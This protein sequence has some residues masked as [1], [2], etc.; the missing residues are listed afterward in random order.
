MALSLALSETHVIVLGTAFA[1]WS[2]PWHC[3]RRKWLS[4]A[5][6]LARRLFPTLSPSTSWRCKHSA[7]VSPSLSA[8]LSETPPKPC[9]SS[10]NRHSRR[11]PPL[12]PLQRLLRLLPSR[13]RRSGPLAAAL[14]SAALANRG[15]DPGLL[16]ALNFFFF[17]IYVI[18]L[19]CVKLSFHYARSLALLH[20]V[21][22]PPYTV[23]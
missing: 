20:C 5:L 11:P 18:R 23:T 7:K 6:S 16:Y 15:R 21:T 9:R 19:H 22:S 2:R 4:P 14:A 1:T 13:L 12:R 10:G 8:L 17:F 3:Q